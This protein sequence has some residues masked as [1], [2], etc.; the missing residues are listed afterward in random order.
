MGYKTCYLCKH[1]SESSGICSKTN[2]VKS[3]NDYC[4][5]IE[6]IP[7]CASCEHWSLN[8]DYL[9]QGNCKIHKG[10][11]PATSICNT[12]DYKEKTT[13]FSD[14]RSRS[15]SYSA[16]SSDASS[17][18]PKS[19][20][21]K[22]ITITVILIVI[23]ALILT[24]I[25]S[26][27]LNFAILPWQSQ[28]SVSSDQNDNYKPGTYY[29][30]SEDGV[31]LMDSPS[32]D[33]EVLLVIP[34]KETIEVTEI[35]NGWAKT[36]VLGKTGYCRVKSIAPEGKIDSKLKISCKY[37]DLTI[38]EYWEDNYVVEENDEYDEW[39]GVFHKLSDYENSS[40]DSKG[41]L[42]SIALVEKNPSHISTGYYYGEL[43]A[44]KDAY[45]Q[46]QSQPFLPIFTLIC[47][48]IF[49]MF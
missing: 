12:G 25:A 5:S 6:L 42:F 19:K 28:K 31:E 17:P 15:A 43:K 7:C 8:Y 27:V 30:T 20:K 35:K 37:Y 9:D 26:M 49:R 38:P 34:Y 18:T 14:A 16:P 3:E 13:T 22:W 47:I 10:L 39:T 36:K 21:G 33:G 2:T 23:G 1:W 44:D 40:S 41:Y 29:V 48:R 45:I 24:R 32:D 11:S 46:T 4:S